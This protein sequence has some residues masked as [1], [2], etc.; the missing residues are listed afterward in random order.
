MPSSVICTFKVCPKVVSKY[1][2]C[3]DWNAFLHSGKNESTRGEDGEDWAHLAFGQNK[4]R[5]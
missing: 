3:N 2:D 4:T 5:K 1:G